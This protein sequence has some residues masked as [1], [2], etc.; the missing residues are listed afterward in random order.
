MKK[1]F[2]ILVIFILISSFNIFRVSSTT[3]V[4]IWP[5]FHHDLQH[6]GQSPY[7]TSGNDGTLK[8]KYQTGSGI[9]SSPAIGSDGTIYVG[10]DDHYLYAL[11]PDGTL[12]WRYQTGVNIN[13]SPAIGSDGTIYVGSHDHYLYALNPDG[14]LKWRYQTGVNIN[15]S[16]AIGSDGTIYVGSHDHY[17]YALNPDGTLKWRYQTGSG[18]GSSP[19]IG[20]DGTI[21]VGSDDHYLY[22][23][24]PDGTLK[25]RYQTGVNINSSPAIGSDGTIYVGSHDHYIEGLDDHYLYALNP[26]GNLKWKFRTGDRIF[27]SPAISSDGTIYVGSQGPYLYA[28]NPN[29][30]L[31]WKY[32]TGDIIEPSP[33][34]SSD[35]TIYVG[36]HDY[37]LYA[38]N[39]DGTLKWKYKTGKEVVS[40]PAIGS[41]GTIYVGSWDNY[42]YAI[43]PLSYSITVN[44][45]DSGVVSKNPDK[46]FYN[47]GESVTLTATPSTGYH[48]VD[49]KGDVA[50][51]HETDNPLRV[52]M[53]VYKTITATF[54]INTYTITSSAGI[55]GTILPSGT[56]TVNYG[57]SK[58]FMITPSPGYKISD[59]KVD[60][61]SVGTVSSY[62]FSNIIANHTIGA[63]FKKEIIII[64]IILQIGNNSFTVNG[65]SNTLDSPPVIKNSRTLLPIRALIESLGGTVG[66]D[67][68][69]KKVSVSLGSK[70]I[71]LWIG[72]SIANV[73][74]IDTPIDATNSKVVPEIIN[75]RTMLP[76][77]FVTENLGCNVQWDGTT[78]TITI[79]YSG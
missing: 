35:G 23:L 10:S 21:Y 46:P 40:S 2:T 4:E 34:I 51:G 17:L 45:I 55:G 54:E 31:K 53:D 42:L 63:I 19:A 62:T 74:G 77:R 69:E 59:V 26:G 14:T 28:L 13:S 18:I 47:S 70:T 78:K 50:Q 72:K 5:M 24:N 25:W 36:S 71:E 43:G 32:K 67:A 29:G 73:N 16:P 58:P 11:N 79:T 3:H 76:L 1:L 22:A 30:T 68:T 9:I 75:S 39:V 38:L 64:T 61:V 57:D 7:D 27:S 66:W 65:V 33:A 41:D 37:Y 44:V 49:W 56:I 6:T 60:G 48:F 12:K 52:T 8:W 15:S 20:S